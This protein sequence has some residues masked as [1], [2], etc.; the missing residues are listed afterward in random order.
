M[1]TDD[2]MLVVRK[3][4]PSVTIGATAELEHVQTIS[5]GSETNY[6]R[7]CEWLIVRV[8]MQ[9]GQYLNHTPFYEFPF[10]QFLAIYW[11][12]CATETA[13]AV[14]R[15]GLK[16]AVLA[17]PGFLMNVFV[18]S[19]LS[20]AFL[21]LAFFSFLIRTV[22]GFKLA[23]EYEQLLLENPD[24]DEFDF[25]QAIDSRI[26]RIDKVQGKNVYALRVPRH[27]AFTSI[28]K[29]LALSSARFNLLSVSGQK[30]GLQMELTIHNNDAPRLLWLKQRAH[31]DVIF[32]YKNPIDPS[33]THVIV[34][35]KI[36]HLFPLLRDC[37]PFEDDRSLSIVQI[38]DHFD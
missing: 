11:S 38:F 30:D 31:L 32:E 35:V 12:L 9:F 13:L 2:I 25:R 26:D 20:I 15:C 17:S 6:F 33:Q 19:F 23:P 28:V 1:V 3:P 8:T 29:K 7:P 18:G 22:G 27:H 4:S 10:V 14:G 37:A 21:Q 5:V 36:G 24:G 34:R 16:T